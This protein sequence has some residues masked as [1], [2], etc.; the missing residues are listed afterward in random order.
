M[1]TYNANDTMLQRSDQLLLA[2]ENHHFE[3]STHLKAKE[4]ARRD[5]GGQIVGEGKIFESKTF[6]YSPNCEMPPPPHP[7]SQCLAFAHW[8]MVVSANRVAKAFRN[9]FPM[10]GSV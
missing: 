8:M 10:S 4:G 2:P 6:F 9:M 5:W 3:G 1:G 7:P